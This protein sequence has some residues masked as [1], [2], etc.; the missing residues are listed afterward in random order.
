MKLA[1]I[2]TAVGCSK[3]SASSWRSGRVVPALRHWAALAALVG[4]SLPKGVDDGPGASVGTLG[5]VVHYRDVARDDYEHDAVAAML[6]AAGYFGVGGLIMEDSAAR[7]LTADLSGWCETGD[8]RVHPGRIVDHLEPFRSGPGSARIGCSRSREVAVARQPCVHLG[9]PA[10]L[11]PILTCCPPPIRSRSSAA[12]GSR[13]A[14]WAL[15][16]RGG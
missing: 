8:C 13:G 9:G 11:S 12:P 3:A 14:T 1:E 10:L 6:D 15:L 5:R 16:R 2:M 4:V 7:A